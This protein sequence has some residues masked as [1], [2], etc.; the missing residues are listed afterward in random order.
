MG[1]AHADAD[2]VR[3][4]Y[5][6]E[7]LVQLRRAPEAH[8][9]TTRSGRP[10]RGREAVVL[11]EADRGLFDAL[12]AWRREEASRQAVPPYVIFHDRTLTE[13]AGA[14]PGSPAA[15]GNVNG[16]GEGKLA[17]YGAAVLEVVAGFA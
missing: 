13:I 5:R 11:E 12:R 10:R 6:N 9:A 8:D 17:R 16:V 15:L 3:A 14:R 7:R 4:V 2:A 1:L